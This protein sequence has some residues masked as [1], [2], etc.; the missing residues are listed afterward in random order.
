M[1][2]KKVSKIEKRRNIF[3]KMSTPY[4]TSQKIK[5]AFVPPNPKEF[6]KE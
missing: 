3:L 4:S 2:I 5:D 1:N 6:D